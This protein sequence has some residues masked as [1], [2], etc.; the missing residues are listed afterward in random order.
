[1]SRSSSITY[2]EQFNENEYVFRIFGQNIHCR[3]I[4]FFTGLFGFLCICVVF[5]LAFYGRW[6]ISLRY[7]DPVDLL[8]ILAFLFFITSGTFVHV[9]IM[10]AVKKN[11]VSLF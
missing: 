3:V 7:E 9:S 6:N 10:M 2:L 11:D 8:A 5:V 1:M 4:T